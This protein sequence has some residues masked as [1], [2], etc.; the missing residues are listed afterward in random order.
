MLIF[1]ALCA[2]A[3]GFLLG[4]R[5]SRIERAGL[6]WLPLPV[7]A[8]LL[9]VLALRLNIHFLGNALLVLSYCLLFV[10]LIRNRHFRLPALALGLGSLLNLTV[11]AANG[12]CMP[13]SSDAAATLSSRGYESILAGEIPMYALANETTRLGFLGD[14]IWFPVPLFRGFA[15]VGDIL[16]TAGIVLLILWI[17]APTRPAVI[18]A[19]LQGKDA[20]NSPKA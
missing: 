7:A 6:Y 8:L 17:M 16:M 10:F 5:L 4:G 12:F 19:G 3:A 18:F 1:G 11:I 9:R 2:I 20:P 15:S 13:V 14:I